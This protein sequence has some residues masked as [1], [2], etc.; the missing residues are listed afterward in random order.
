MDVLEKY[1]KSGGKVLY[2]LKQRREKE[3]EIFEKVYMRKIY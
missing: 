1:N 3:R 2:G